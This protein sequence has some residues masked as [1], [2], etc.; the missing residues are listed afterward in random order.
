MLKNKT[1]KNMSLKKKEKNLSK[2]S[3]SSKLKL[4]SQTHN[5]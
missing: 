4:I 2:S 3:E 5:L 1:K